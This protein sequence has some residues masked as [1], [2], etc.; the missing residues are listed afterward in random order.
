GGAAR[1]DAEHGAGG[2]G[3]AEGGGGEEG[4]LRG[5]HGRDESNDP[6]P[7]GDRAGRAGDRE[8]RLHAGRHEDGGDVHVHDGHAGD[9]RDVAGRADDDERGDAAAAGG[10]D[11]GVRSRGELGAG[12]ARERGGGAVRG[13][14]EH[15]TGGG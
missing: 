7:D 3:G 1:G 5:E 14:A 9:Q 15:G 4:Q 6:E 10:R 11:D 2:G 13:D 12:G 8:R